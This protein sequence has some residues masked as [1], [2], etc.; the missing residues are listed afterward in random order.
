MT[1]KNCHWETKAGTVK[2]YEMLKYVVLTDSTHKLE[3]VQH[4]DWSKMCSCLEIQ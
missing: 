2:T 1:S 4:D 3:I